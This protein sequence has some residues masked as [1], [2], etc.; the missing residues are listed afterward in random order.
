MGGMP[1]GFK[2]KLQSN[3]FTLDCGSQRGSFTLSQSMKNQISNLSI[4]LMCFLCSQ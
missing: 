4:C 1:Y 2:I 3:G